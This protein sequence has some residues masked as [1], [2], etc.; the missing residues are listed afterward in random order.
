MHI[1]VSKLTIIGSDHGLSPGRRQAIIWTN[2][3]IF[4][5]WTLR[6]KLQWIFNRNSNIF[7]QENASEYVAWEISTISSRP[8]CVNERNEENGSLQLWK[9]AKILAAGA[10]VMGSASAYLTLYTRWQ[11]SKPYEVSMACISNYTPQSSMRYNHSFI[12]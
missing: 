12:F 7:I 9:E 10:Y 8:Q 11:S 3:G 1:C 5:N 2:A 4:F 6:N